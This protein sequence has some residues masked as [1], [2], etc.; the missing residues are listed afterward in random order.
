MQHEQE[1]E[2]II[3]FAD[4]LDHAEEGTRSGWVLFASGVT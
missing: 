3:A 1:R 2:W 4:I